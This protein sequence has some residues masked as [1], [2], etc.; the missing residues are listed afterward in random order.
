[1]TNK[2]KVVITDHGFADVD[3]ESR[4][5]SEAGY[6]LEVAHCETAEQVK[7]AVAGASGLLVQL[8][9]VSAWALEELADC[10]V[11]VR[12]GIGYDNVDIAAAAQLGIPVCNV[13]HY[14]V[15]E[16][17]DHTLAMALTLGRQLPQLHQ[18]VASG[19]WQLTPPRP[20]PAFRKMTFGAAGFGRIARAVLHRARAFGFRVVAYDPYVTAAEFEGAGVE[21][22]SAEELLCQSDVLSLHLPLTPETRHFLN[23]TTLARMKAG[24]VVVNT[25]R[26]PLIDTLALAEALNSGHLGGAG[27]DVLEEE[28]MPLQHPLRHCPGVLLSS[29]NAWYSEASLPLLKQLATEEVVRGLRGEPLQHQVNKPRSQA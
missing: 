8:A 25:A 22:L 29:H 11:I 19:D 12:Y 1:M 2:L 14:C 27:L 26:G 13:P 18:R 17:A 15:D 24:A 3:I 16:V 10:R 7:A 5:L 9:P 23:G 21:S 4:I 28:P 6:L 20:M